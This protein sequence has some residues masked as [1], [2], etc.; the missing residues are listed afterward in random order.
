[1]TKG[2]L[3]EKAPDPAVRPQYSAD[4]PA[5]RVWSNALNLLRDDCR[6]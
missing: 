3:I 4:A 1:M 6:V 2:P 5:A